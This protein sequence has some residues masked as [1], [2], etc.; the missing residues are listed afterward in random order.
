MIEIDPTFPEAWN[1][2]ATIHF[3]RGDYAQSLADVA[4]TL[5]LEPRHF[6]ALAGRGIIRLRQG[7]S[8]LAI[9]SIKAALAFHPFLRERTLIPPQFLEPSGQAL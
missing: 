5:E 4:T 9:Q 7:K 2:R 3:L 8:A 1:Q 6:G